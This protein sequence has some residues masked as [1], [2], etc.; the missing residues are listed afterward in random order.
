MLHARQIH[1][2]CCN[3]RST[4]DR[5]VSPHAPQRT[6][7]GSMAAASHVAP[8]CRNARSRD[9]QRTTA[10][11]VH[12]TQITDLMTEALATA[13]GPLAGGSA[14]TTSFW[15]GTAARTTRKSAWA[16]ALSR[17]MPI[18]ALAGAC[19]QK[20]AKA[21]SSRSPPLGPAAAAGHLGGLA[22]FGRDG[23]RRM[24]RGLAESSTSSRGSLR[25]LHLVCRRA[26]LRLHRRHRLQHAPKTSSPHASRSSLRMHMFWLGKSRVR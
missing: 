24:C 8:D 10:T 20:A 5:S 2:A 1:R 23:A 21:S 14:L 18:F 7:T 22:S 16:T 25:H 17:L 13:C 26:Q 9:Q 19:K 3:C 15:E 12:P 11:A 4:L 6:R